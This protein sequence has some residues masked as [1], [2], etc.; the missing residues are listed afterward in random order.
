M[1]P[2][3][4]ENNVNLTSKKKMFFFFFFLGGGTFNVPTK[5]I[6]KGGEKNQS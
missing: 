4:L 2:D 5:Y 3:K 6:E 1:L